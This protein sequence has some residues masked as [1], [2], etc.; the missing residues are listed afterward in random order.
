[1]LWP[2]RNWLKIRI[3]WR[4]WKTPK[5]FSRSS[6]RVHPNCRC[7]FVPV[8]KADPDLPFPSGQ[9]I[10]SGG[11]GDAIFTSSHGRLPSFDLDVFRV[12]CQLLFGRQPT[13]EEV[14]DAL[15]KI[16]ERVDRDIKD[17]LK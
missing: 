7:I 2:P 9:R 15:R 16:A 11:S 10:Q 17:K 5:T 14:D 4:R 1:M 8:L 6:A 12:D 13:K 3:R